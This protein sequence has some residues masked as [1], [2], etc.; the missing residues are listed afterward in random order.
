MDWL[1]YSWT[2]LEMLHSDIV[3]RSQIL[4]GESAQMVAAMPEPS[5]LKLRVGTLLEEAEGGDVRDAFAAAS[6]ALVG[7]LTAAT[8]ALAN[9][10]KEVQRCVLW[11][12]VSAP[13]SYSCEGVT[14]GRT[15]QS[16]ADSFYL[17][18]SLAGCLVVM[19]TL[20]VARGRTCLSNLASGFCW[21]CLCGCVGS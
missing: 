9:S 21:W 10:Q 16:R 1:V 2:K 11:A 3:G 20:C 4:G 19:E 5:A 13:P 15:E 7:A 17:T 12:R 8:G 6:L 18:S 14:T